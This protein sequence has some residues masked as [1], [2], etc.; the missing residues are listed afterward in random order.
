MAAASAGNQNSWVF[1]PIPDLLFG[2]GLLYLVLI[3]GMIVGGDAAR[4]SISP[5]WGSL[6]ILIV[7]GA[8]YGATLL[9]VYEHRAE[10]DTYRIFTVYGTFAMLAML[11]GALYSPMAGSL[12][13]SLYLTWSPWHYTGQNYGIAVMFLRRRGVELA[14]ATKRWLYAS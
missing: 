4:E 12:L 3:S 1:G 13:I 8:H 9:R 7:S 11:V 6:L 14:P 5:V 10:R 2:S